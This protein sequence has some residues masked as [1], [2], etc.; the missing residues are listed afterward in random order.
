MIDCKVSEVRKIKIGSK[1]ECA[2]QCGEER[3]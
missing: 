1:V 3:T 2:T